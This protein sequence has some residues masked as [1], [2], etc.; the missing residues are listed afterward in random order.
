MKGGWPVAQVLCTRACTAHGR[1]VAA[2]LLSIGITGC[3]PASRFGPLE[4][5]WS[6]PLGTQSVPIAA[7]PAVAYGRVYIGSWNGWEYAFDEASGALRWRTFL[8]KSDS[9]SGGPAR[10]VTSSPWLEDGVAYLGGGDSYWYALDANGGGVLWRVLVGNAT[11]P[12]GH[13]NWSSPVAHNGYAYVGIASH[14]DMPLVQGKLLRVSL[15]THQIA[16]EWKVV[17]D[18]QVGG[19]IWTSPVLDAA[20]NTVYVTTGNHASDS[21]GNNQP[22]SQSLVAVDATT[23]GIKGHWQLPA[24][25]PTPDADWPT[26]PTLFTDAQGRDLVSAAHKNGKVYAFLRDSLSAGPVWSRQMAAPAVGDEPGAGGVY[27]NGFFDGQR[28]YYAGGR[29]TIGGRTVEGSIRAFNPATGATVWER[30]LPAKTYGALT[31]ANGMVVVPALDAL[32][33]LDGATG[34]V[35]FANDLGHSIFGAAT[36]ANGRLFI[37]DTGSFAHAFRYPPAPTAAARASAGTLTVTVSPSCSRLG[38]LPETGRASKVGRIAV[39]ATTPTA[40]AAIRV[41]A[42]AS[43]QGRPTLR[44]NLANG[45]AVVDTKALRQGST[46]SARSRDPVELK[47]RIAPPRSR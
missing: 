20:R 1:I 27:S 25:D 43:C 4:E 15:S 26:S 30:A 44:L 39:R 37:G 24:S 5:E 33:L 3:H 21:T 28:L 14:C 40:R 36:V 6:V 19:T 45:G 32:R 34:D 31:G 23:L 8:G 35:L 47:L 46:Y 22:Y 10:G 12:G 42:N 17:P 18:G 16:N 41:Y 11:A 38:T 9:C 13:Y 2:A 29:T 7:K